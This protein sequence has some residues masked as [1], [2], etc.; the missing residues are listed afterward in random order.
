MES[1]IR[2]RLR[3]GA[4]QLG[5]VVSEGQVAQLS[6]YLRMLEKWNTAYNLTAIK[7]PLE[8]VG[9]HILD[10]LAIYP[11]LRGDRFID[12]GTGAGLP[13]MVLAIQNPDI[14]VT[15]L[16]SNGK[17]T[18]FLSQVK[19]Q[20]GLKNIEV[21]HSRVD[22]YSPEQGFDGVLSR[23]FASLKDMTDNAAHLVAEGGRFW[24]MKGRYPQQEIDE[25]DSKF[26]LENSQSLQV[27]EVS[28]ERHLIELKLN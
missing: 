8:M 7:D 10:S 21:V 25:L 28:A 22:A 6:A 14:F 27:P 24:A 15:L 4:E 13:G 17:K 9:L 18:R 20:L 1:E 26:T 3:L 11:H 5:I 19:L 16:D 23:A 2:S 12:V